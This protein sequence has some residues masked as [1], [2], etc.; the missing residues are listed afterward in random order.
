MRGWREEEEE[1]EGERDQ[2]LLQSLTDPREVPKSGYYY[3]VCLWIIVRLRDCVL[4]LRVV[5]GLRVH[6]NLCLSSDDDFRSE[7]HSLL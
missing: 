1:R 6:F 3:E 2:R 4:A 5:C 7:R